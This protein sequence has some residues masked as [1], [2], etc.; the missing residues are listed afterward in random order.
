MA[1][2]E[3]LPVGNYKGVM[4]C[5]RPD[6]TAPVRSRAPGSGI[7]PSDAHGP[8]FLPPGV[9]ND[10]LGL[11]P[12][13]D[14]VVTNVNAISEELTEL[15]ATRKI[16]S[17]NAN[18]LYKHKKWLQQLSTQKRS[19]A[20]AAAAEAERAERLRAKLAKSAVAFSSRLRAR[21]EA[22]ASAVHAAGGSGRALH[23]A[24][25]SSAAGAVAGG[26]DEAAAQQPG[27]AAAGERATAHDG[28][29]TPPSARPRPSS[30]ANGNALSNGH[31][32]NPGNAKGAVAKPMWAMTEG[33]ALAKEAAAEDDEL[34]SLLNFAQ[35]AP[36]PRW[37]ELLWRLCVLCL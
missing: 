35:G 18:Y 19:E 3:P 36:L 13:R 31:G 26:G 27:L 23:A 22:A 6:D 7:R 20:E 24:A 5:N 1:A 32:V 2:A 28:T 30:A 33:A 34:A 17:R 9:T 12:A 16:N 25:S 14:N 37:A 10:G 21:R 4:L 8:I 29:A 11:N 15:R